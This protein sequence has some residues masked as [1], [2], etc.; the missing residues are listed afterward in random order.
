MR[1]YISGK[2]SGLPEDQVTEKFADMENRV[3]TWGWKPVN[4]AT[5]VMHTDCE[6]VDY[7]VEDIA[8][9]FGCDAIV[10]LPDW[11]QSNGARIEHAI[12]KMRN[13]VVLYW[14]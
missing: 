13:M 8:L 2:I 4:P 3:R 14:S 10:M 1:C 11:Q 5:V 6:W 9:L 12:A 7:M